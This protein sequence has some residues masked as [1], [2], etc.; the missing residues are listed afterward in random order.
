M[1]ENYK[2]IILFILSLFLL[3]EKISGCSSMDDRK[4]TIVITEVDN[5]NKINIDSKSTLS[6][7]LQSQPST[8]YSWV[9]NE[10]D[11]TKLN[12]IQEFYNNMNKDDSLVGAIVLQV[13]EFKVVSD[14]TLKLEFN[15]KQVWEKETTPL[16]TFYIEVLIKTKY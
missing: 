8:G 4:D 3:Q 7:K 9:L 5:G 11:S 13:F 6:I 14:G 12:L 1:N 10:Y 2:F 15:Y 16:K